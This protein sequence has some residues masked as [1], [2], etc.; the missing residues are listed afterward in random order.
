MGLSGH[1]TFM[2]LTKWNPRGYVEG[3]TA[4]LSVFV[5]LEGFPTFE[6]LQLCKESERVSH[7]PVLTV[8]Q[9]SVMPNARP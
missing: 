3:L 8:L 1:K 9:I 2:K 4:G 7:T 5:C 6:C